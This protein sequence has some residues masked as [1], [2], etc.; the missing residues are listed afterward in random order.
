M[1]NMWY[2]Y[3]GEP[4]LLA[5]LRTIPKERGRAEEKDVCVVGMG[6]GWWGKSEWGWRIDMEGREGGQG[7]S[8][9]V[10][11]IHGSD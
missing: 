10:Q 7:N 11:L 1:A 3:E 9:G 8:N 4:M 2:P 5:A 6:G